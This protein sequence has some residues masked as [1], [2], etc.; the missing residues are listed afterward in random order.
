MKLHIAIAL[1]LLVGSC[2]GP[3]SPNTATTTPGSNSDTGYVWTKVLDSGTWKKSYNFQMFTIHD[4]LWIFHPDGNWFSANGKDWTKSTLPN[5]INNLAFLKYVYFN[6]AVYGLGHFEGNIEQFSFRPEIYRTTDFIHWDTISKN[7]NLP[8][9]FFYQPFVFNN[10]IWIIGGADK[11]GEYAD[12][13]NS[14][15][16]VNWSKQKDNLPFGKRIHSKII[17]FKGMLYLLN[18][19]VWT[20]TDGLSWK[21]LT[22]ELIKGEDIFGY[23]IAIL[24]NKIWLLG[25]NRNGQFSS[26]VL[27]SEDGKNWQPKDAP[28]TARGGIASSVFKDRIYM[29]G[30][31]YG[32]TPNQPEFIYSNDLWALG[33][34]K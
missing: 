18:N 15:D 25:C 19:D 8:N 23:S 26:Q 24:D 31:K 29:T 2:S 11:N 5:S 30:G 6:N 7:S 10:K 28:W 27:V 14:P 3:S 4:S 20:S 33:K 17:S 1:C 32:G 34:K 12:V 9:R 16:A 13:W 21:L 22:K